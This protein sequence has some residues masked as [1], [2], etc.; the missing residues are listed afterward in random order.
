MINRDMRCCNGFVL[1]FDIILTSTKH[2][3]GRYPYWRCSTRI[4]VL[5]IF[6]LVRSIHNKLVA[7]SKFLAESAT[8]GDSICSFDS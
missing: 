2:A 5:S 3:N 4:F 8:G 1:I 7:S 6:V